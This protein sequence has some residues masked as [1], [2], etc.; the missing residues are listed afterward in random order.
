MNPAFCPKCQ[1]GTVTLFEPDR[2]GTIHN[3]CSICRT[4]RP[5]KP[6]VTK[7]E[8]AANTPQ[9]PELI[10]QLADKGVTV[11]VFCHRCNRE[12]E[13]VF[14]PLTSGLIGNCCSICRACRKGRPY[15]SE[16][17]YHQFKRHDAQQG[18]G[19]QHEDQ[20]RTP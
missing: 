16:K 15:V 20:S 4:H 6:F 14:L 18:Q 12:T 10:K 1:Q 11:S 2:R 8:V 19:G 17:E 7:S 13:T 9:E 5:G 3:R